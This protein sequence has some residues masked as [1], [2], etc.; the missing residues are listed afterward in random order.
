MTQVVHRHER[1]PQSRIHRRIT[2]RIVHFVSN[3]P[4][5]PTKIRSSPAQLAPYR[6]R[7]RFVRLRCRCSPA[8]PHAGKV[9]LRTPALLLGGPSRYPVRQCTTWRSIRT[10]PSAQAT[11]DQRSPSASPSRQPEASKKSSRSALTLPCCSKPRMKAPICASCHTTSRL[12]ARGVRRPAGLRL[13]SPQRQ[14]SRNERCK[15]RWTICTVR[16]PFV[17]AK[18][19][20]G[21]SGRRA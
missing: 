8:R 13:I 7:H 10:V 21:G 2:R 17:L 11:S 6:R 4:L 16:G 12:G 19:H 14:A 18:S 5:S 3:A 20:S 1:Q 9:M 15:T